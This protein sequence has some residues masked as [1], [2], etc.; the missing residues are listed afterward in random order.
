MMVG[1]GVV[2]VMV[3]VVQGAAA[4]HAAPDEGRH[5]VGENRGKGRSK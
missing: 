2:V 5:V 4:T 1:V 3:Y